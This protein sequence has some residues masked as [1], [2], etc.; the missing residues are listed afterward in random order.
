MT[1][2]L[3]I[4]NGKYYAVL[5]IR[6]NGKRKQKWIC[7][8]FSEKGNKKKA[9]KFLRE[10]IAEYENKPETVKNDML[11]SDYIRLW[12]EQKRFSV[13][14][15]TFQGYEQLAK[16]HVIPYFEKTRVKLQEVDAEAL[17]KFIDEKTE[18]GRKDNTG[19]LSARSVKLM[20]NIVNQ[21]LVLALKNKLIINNPCAF[22]TM[23]PIG[24]RE[25]SFYTAEQME[26]FLNAI[27]DEPIYPVIKTTAFYGLR[28]SEVLGLRWSS[29]NFDTNSLVIS[30]TVVKIN[31]V[32]CKD[33]TKNKS[34]Y[35]SFPLLPEIKKLLQAEFE[36]QQCNK[37]EFGR[38]YT[39]SPYV[40]VWDNGVPI[41]PDVLTKSFGRL[42]KKY[43]FPH[44]RFH[45]IR[46]SCASILLS[47]GF[48]LKDVQE[49]LGH[50]DIKMTANVY[51]HLDLGRKQE[52]ANGISMALSSA[53]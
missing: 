52:I 48:T 7:S 18:H 33:R 31:T 40:F 24:R 32:V 2:N 17:Q 4:K 28:R 5:N 21:T 51:G 14:S 9:E 43:G 30:H 11:F 13:E 12:L 16:S 42:L 8:E 37:K 19:R 50:A 15:T 23:P 35:R 10:K 34:S 41:R 39:E 1:G 29:I 22:I 38:A 6:E 26:R 20:R 49:W 44:I 36:K 45:D 25:P 47:K 46:H 53:G 3:Q 27:K